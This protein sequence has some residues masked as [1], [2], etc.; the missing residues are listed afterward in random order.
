MAD[1]RERLAAQAEQ[2]ARAAHSPGPAATLRRARARRKP[3]LARFMA[4]RRTQASGT[5]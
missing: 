4:T 1:L 3:S 5:A 2:A